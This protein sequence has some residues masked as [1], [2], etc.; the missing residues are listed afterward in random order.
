MAAPAVTWE[1]APPS[2]AVTGSVTSEEPSLLAG[3]TAAAAGPPPPLPLPL[4]TLLLKLAA[5]VAIIVM[6]VLGNLLVIV[7]VL[8][9]RRIRVVANC[10]VV[11]LAFAD[12]LVALCAMTFN[13]SIQITGKWMFG[14]IMCDMWNSFDVFFSTVSI[15]HLC[16][17]SV[18]RYCAIMRPLEYRSHMNKRTVAA[19]LIVSWT[20]PVL[21]SF[22]P[23]FLGWYTYQSH[24][25]YRARHPNTCQFI[26][27]RTY[28]LVS[29]TISFWLPGVVM[30]CMY[31]RIYQEARRQHRAIRRVPSSARFSSAHAAV[32]LADMTDEQLSLALTALNN[33]REEPEPEPAAELVSPL[34]AG[35]GNGE[36]GN[37][38]GNGSAE[39]PPRPHRP[40]PLSKKASSVS[41]GEKLDFSRKASTNSRLGRLRYSTSQMLREHKAAKTLGV[42]MGCFV[43]CWLPFFSWYATTTLCGR[44]CHVPPVLVDIL[45]WIGYFNSTLNPMIYAYFNTEFRDAFRQTL[46]LLCCRRRSGS[47]L[48][49]PSNLSCPPPMA[50]DTGNGGAPRPRPCRTPTLQSFPG[51]AARC[52]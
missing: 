47:S 48:S 16:C 24:L 32:N 23:I 1:P 46:S 26:V 3:V 42:I 45:F 44:A 4:P 9:H 36:G 52:E 15:L 31:S 2:G 12:M 8:L 33:I 39:R 11:S 37:G 34:S 20:A 19:M 14:Y 43:L 40:P 21:I 30:V 7:S 10:F 29:S 5:M 27:N 28:M 18:D 25:D 49:R 41:F 13:A 22:V 35:D 6:A 50:G 38:N 51:H 17:I